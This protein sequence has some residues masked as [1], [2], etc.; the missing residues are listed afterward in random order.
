MSCEVII[1]IKYYQLTVTRTVGKNTI[2]TWS[3]LSVLVLFVSFFSCT[4]TD[5]SRRTLR[6]ETVG[7]RF[8]KLR[9]VR[10]FGYLVAIFSRANG[11]ENAAIPIADDETTGSLS[12]RLP[13][14]MAPDEIGR[15]TR[16]RCAPPPTVTRNRAGP[17]EISEK[18]RRNTREKTD[19]IK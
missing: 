16:A 1:A 5:E 9:F 14:S 13:V 19:R 10:L 11:I 8:E 2:G 17:T 4:Q 18:F 3:R 12:N 7:A 15:A 6:W